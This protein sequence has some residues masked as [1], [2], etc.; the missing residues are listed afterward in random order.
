MRAGE[1]DVVLSPGDGGAGKRVWELLPVL[2]A[3]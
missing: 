3:L 2:T 1:R